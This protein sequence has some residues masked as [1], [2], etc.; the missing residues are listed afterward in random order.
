MNE[1]LV[2]E[3]SNETSH[4]FSITPGEEFHCVQVQAVY[5]DGITSVKAVATD[6]ST[7]SVDEQV[8]GSFGLYPNPASEA[9][10]I[11]GFISKK[12]MM[13]NALGQLVKAFGD[14][15]QIPL[16]DL[17]DGLYHLVATDEKGTI[18]NTKVIIN[19]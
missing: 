2:A 18:R 8:F 13:Y 9:V 5:G 14:A 1:T 3:N 12:N 7:W 15:Q 16:N 6:N 4:I 19:H 17:P 11:Q 10:Y